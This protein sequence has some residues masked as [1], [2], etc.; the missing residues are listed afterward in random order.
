MVVIV[1]VFRASNARC[2]GIRCQCHVW[3]LAH[4]DACWRACI[5]HAGEVA[6]D[7]GHQHL[8]H[9]TSAVHETTWR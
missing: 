7:A 4:G 6:I 2:G 5:R 8:L 9:V 3:C 1:T